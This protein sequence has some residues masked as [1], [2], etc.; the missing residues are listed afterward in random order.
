V[1]YLVTMTTHV[2]GGTPERDVADIRAREAAHTDELARDGHVLRL[3]RPPL[4]PGEWRTIGLFSAAD[5]AGLE[6]VLASMPLRVWRTDEATALGS[7]PNDPAYQQTLDPGETEFLTTFTIA[8]RISAATLDAGLARE[9]KRTRELAEEGRLIRLWTL[10]G[11]GRNLGL[12]QAQDGQAMQTILQSLPLADWLS[13]DTVQL[14]RHPSD[15]ATRVRR[16][17]PLNDSGTAD[18]LRNR[19]I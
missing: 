4:L 13:V 3:W 10:P 9:A 17:A 18:A 15:P 12:W 7:H 2:P 16:G 11:H 8:P 1:E 19:P 5:S 14:A 6:Q